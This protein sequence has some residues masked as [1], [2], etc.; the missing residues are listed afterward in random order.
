[1]ESKENVVFNISGIRYEI[2]RSCL[3][4][5]SRE[6]YKV[7]SEL[8]CSDGNVTQEF[9]FNRPRQSCESVLDYF[10]T[11]VLHMP[12]NVCPGEFI[13]ELNFW[14]VDPETLEGCCYHR[15]AMF[16]R[17]QEHLAGF[18]NSLD[19]KPTESRSKVARATWRDTMWNILDDNSKTTTG[20]V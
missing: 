11:G 7:S 4:R 19:S 12:N 18:L 13:Q 5:I 15:Y 1:M 16:V 14:G 10:Q 3:S 17:E 20:K 9:T 6:C 8:A 2:Q